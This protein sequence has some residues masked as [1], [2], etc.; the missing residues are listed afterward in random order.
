[1]SAVMSGPLVLKLVVESCTL[2]VPTI[3]DTIRALSSEFREIGDEVMNEHPSY[4]RGLKA[5]N[6][7]YRFHYCTL[8]EKPYVYDGSWEGDLCSCRLLAVDGDDEQSRHAMNRE[9]L[10]RMRLAAAAVGD[11]RDDSS[12]AG[13]PSPR[14][15][16]CSPFLTSWLSPLSWPPLSCSLRQ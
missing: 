4:R 12:F 16:G 15:W 1:M 5:T 6:S 2:D 3:P 10:R 7:S 9:S 14:L 13:L 11:P 8:C